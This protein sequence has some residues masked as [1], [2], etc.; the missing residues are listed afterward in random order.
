MN[1]WVKEKTN[2]F[3]WLFCEVSFQKRPFLKSM[4]EFGALWKHENNQHELVPPETECGCPSGGG[5]R[6]GHVRYP[7]Y[8]G[9]QKKKKKIKGAIWRGVPLK[10]SSWCK[11][12]CFCSLFASFYMCDCN[13]PQ[14]LSLF[15]A[16]SAI[17]AAGSMH[18]SSSYS[19]KLFC[20][21]W[22]NL[23]QTTLSTSHSLGKVASLLVSAKFF[24]HF[25]FY[26]CLSL[27]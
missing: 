25:V 21:V 16:Q 27:C 9:T 11:Y 18:P 22:Q 15:F 23:W 2:L 17:L 19:S 8:E 26:I 14:C 5:I 10:G 4:S 24:P 1:A 12:H 7:F 3:V 13:M 6:N 20:D